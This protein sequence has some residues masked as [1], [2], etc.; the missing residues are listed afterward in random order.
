MYNLN[1]RCLSTFFTYI[2]P[3][4]CLFLEINIFGAGYIFGAAFF[5]D[6]ILALLINDTLFYVDFHLNSNQIQPKRIWFEKKKHNPDSNRLFHACAVQCVFGLFLMKWSDLFFS[7]LFRK[8]IP[9]KLFLCITEMNEDFEHLHWKI[10]FQYFRY[11]HKHK[12]IA[13]REKKKRKRARI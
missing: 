1:N 13:W 4:C 2:R 9:C 3:S 8:K 11:I 6:F 7:L 12:T 5:I 10:V